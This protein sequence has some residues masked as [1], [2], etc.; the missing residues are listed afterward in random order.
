MFSLP[1]LAIY[2]LGPIATTSFGLPGLVPLMRPM[3][4][5]SFPSFRLS[6]L[7]LLSR[8]V[9]LL[10][11]LPSFSTWAWRPSVFDRDYLSYSTVTPLPFPNHL[12]VSAGAERLILSFVHSFIHSTTT[13]IRHESLPKGL[14]LQGERRHELGINKE[15]IRTAVQKWRGSV[16]GHFGDILK[17]MSSYA[18]QTYSGTYVLCAAESRINDWRRSVTCFFFDGRLARY[19]II[20]KNLHSNRFVNH[21]IQFPGAIRVVIVPQISS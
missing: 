2:P 8:R 16:A 14:R 17:S 5:W 13:K 9:L 21:S 11:C 4:T 18:E 20:A 19:V 6:A 1:R 3:K 7:S 12:S 15:L 10:S